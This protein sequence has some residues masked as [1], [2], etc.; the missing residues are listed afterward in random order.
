MPPRLAVDEIDELW[1]LPLDEFTAVRDA[2]AKELRAKGRGDDAAEVAALRKPTVAAWVVNRLARDQ[3]KEVHH[4]VRSAEGIRAGSKGA[5]ERFREGADRLTRLAR[6]VLHDAGRTP[7]DA[8]I[9]DVATTLRVGAA[10]APELLV[11]GRLTQPLE[12]S[13]F[14]AMAGASLRPRPARAETKRPR[15]DRARV[16][17]AREALAAAR[18]DAER[19]RREAATAEREAK[20]IRAEADKA[21]RRV[22]EAEKRL[23]EAR[24]S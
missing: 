2:L 21:A 5:D 16:E 14:A 23:A 4:L 7:T 18:G 15:A 12:P 1:G 3:R 20:R 19:L 13:G 9:R 11:A 22:A 10:E 24:E 6:D 8:V 17:W